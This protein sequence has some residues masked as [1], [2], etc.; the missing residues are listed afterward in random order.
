MTRPGKIGPPL[1][2][3]ARGHCGFITSWAVTVCHAPASDHYLLTPGSGMFVC[4]AHTPRVAE[5]FHPVDRHPV[6]PECIHPASDWQ[7]S[8][9]NH[10]GFCHV[11]REDTELLKQ[12]HTVE[13][14]ELEART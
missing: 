7:Q 10:T 6:T 2:N 12:L 8:T 3:S 5:L 1:P 9:V 14:T 11:P 4:T 13:M